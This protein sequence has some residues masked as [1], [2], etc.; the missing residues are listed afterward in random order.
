M[1]RCTGKP[2]LKEVAVLCAV[3]CTGNNL[4]IPLGP[5]NL[6]DFIYTAYAHVQFLAA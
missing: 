3:T 2:C 6:S 5:I 4:C 1:V